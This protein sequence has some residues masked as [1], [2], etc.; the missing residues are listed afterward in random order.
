MVCPLFFIS[1][2]FFK[3]NFLCTVFHCGVLFV[4]SLFN[5]NFLGAGEIKFQDETDAF[6]G[7]CVYS[8]VI[9]CV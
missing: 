3:E 1:H 5:M 9:H 8:N 6:Y 2:H 7:S 4:T